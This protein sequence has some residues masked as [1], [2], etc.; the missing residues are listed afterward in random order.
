VAAVAGGSRHAIQKFNPMLAGT[1]A[2][3]LLLSAMGL[4]I[5]ATYHLLYPGAAAARMVQLSLGIAVILFVTYALGL[6]FQLGTHR[7]YFAQV[8][9]GAEEM[10]D[11]DV[12]H[13]HWSV[14]RAVTVLVLATLG[15][16]AMS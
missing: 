1:G 12:P 3:M 9:P 5:P 4:I 6:V 15:I 8:G 11:V 10:E 14:T 16:A 2:T 7:R 13:E